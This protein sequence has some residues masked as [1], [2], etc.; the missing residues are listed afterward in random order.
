M[1]F[2]RADDFTRIAVSMRDSGA[3]LASDLGTPEEH[4]LALPADG[5]FD[6]LAQEPLASEVRLAPWQSTVLRRAQPSG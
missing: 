2:R 6:L 3:A 4:T 1:V 5:Y